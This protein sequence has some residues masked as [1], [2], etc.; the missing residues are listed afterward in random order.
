MPA[1]AGLALISAVAAGPAA[2]AT[3]ATTPAKATS[4]KPAP[5]SSTASELTRAFE[6]SRHVPGSAVSGIQ[7]GTLHTG[8]ANGRHWAVASFAPAKAVTPEESVAFQDGAATGVFE[9]AN[10]VWRL[11]RTGSYACGDGLPATLKTAWHVTAPASVCTTSA[12][13]QRAAAQH[14]LAGLPASARAAAATAIKATAAKVRPAGAATAST[15]MAASA[16]NPADFRQ[17]IAAIAL[18]QVGHG[19]TPVENNF[20]GVDCD[21]YSSMVAGFSANSDGCGYDTT[22]NVEN[23]NETWCSDFNKW[24]WEQTGITDDINTINAGAVSYYTWA[25]EHG[26]SPQPDTGTPQVGDSILFFSKSSFPRFADHVGLVTA[27]H[28]DGSIDM[29]NGDFAANPDIHVEYDQDITNLA[30]FA[31]QVEGNSTEEWVI[32]SPPSTAQA[33]APTGHLTGPAV[34]VA[35]STGDFHASGTVAGSSVSAYYWTFGDGRTTNASGPDVKHAFSEPGT[36][37]VAVTITSAAGAAVTLTQD[38]HVLA[39]SSAVVSVPD[40]GVWYDPLP[41]FQYAFT[42]SPGGLAVDSWNGGSWLQLAVPG[43]PSATGNF[44][45]LAYPDADNADAMTPHVF[46]RASG[47]SLAETY[48]TTSGWV[49]K[50]LPGSPVAGGTIVATNTT[51]VSGDPEVFFVDAAGNLA[52]TSLSG[53]TWT[54]RTVISASDFPAVTPS[55]L[56]LADTLT[57]PVLFATGPAGTIRVA[58]PDGGAW[59]SRAIPAKTSSGAPLAA[60]TTPDGH[61]AVVFTGAQGGLAEAAEGGATTADQ[62]D[63]T[64][65]PGSPAAGSTLAATDYPLPSQIPATPGDFPNPYGSLTD[66]N[67]AEPFGTEAFYLTASGAPAV[68]YNDG[69]GWKTATLPSVS[70]ATAIAGATAFAV[71][72]EPSDLFLSGTGGLSEETT[73]ARSGDP[74]GTWTS[75][76]LP[77]TPAT[78]ANQVILYAADPTD[79][80]AARAAAQAAGL[81]ASSVTTSFAT[82]WA[83]TLNGD[84]YLVLAVGG[85]AVGALY[86]NKCGWLNPS[87]LP[88][89]GTPFFYYVGEWNTPP[90]ADAYVNAASDTAADTQTLAT[91]LAYYALHGTLPPGVTT[92]PAPV[93]PPNSCVGSPS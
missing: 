47:G 31:Q 38:V 9:Q 32:V 92:T 49:T 86:Y 56:S 52:E 26:Q 54:T 46:Y 13:A 59:A 64:A 69:T 66:S 63:V 74:S 87:G 90:G 75:M 77:D 42:R 82:A 76:A 78:W 55:S 25:T 11:V 2:A 44:A 37:T 12:A 21:P 34:A 14:S 72:E 73:G 39:P 57:G 1:V 68:S 61:A 6:A 22:Y 18:S 51:A 27:V 60:Q 84:T 33:P 35:G 5:A 3:A 15:A 70:G 45:A 7:A 40:D 30:A 36:Y 17:T 53:G 91:D 41:V 88:A 80:A 23:E 93:G 71:E 19:A 20:N 81:P 58:S 67:V 28:P 43:D 8:T 65:L 89:G 24:V 29:V 50:D 79:A 62:W 4:V 10:G 48:R 83:D 85:P 16:T